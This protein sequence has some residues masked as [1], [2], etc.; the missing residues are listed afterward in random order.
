MHLYP[1]FIP[2]IQGTPSIQFICHGPRCHVSSCSFV[3][4]RLPCMLLEVC[5][6]QLELPSEGDGDSLIATISQTLLLIRSRFVLSFTRRKLHV[7]SCNGSSVSRQCFI[8]CSMTFCDVC[9]LPTCIAIQAQKYKTA[10]SFRKTLA[11]FALF[12]F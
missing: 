10:E 7:N 9:F 6:T 4:P 5:N 1:N 2:D 8:F 12:I 3:A 11:I